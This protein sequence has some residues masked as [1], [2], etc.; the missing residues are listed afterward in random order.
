VKNIR[1][2]IE[3]LAA[4]LFRRHVAWATH[5]DIAFGLHL[6][7]AM[8]A[9]VALAWCSTNFSV[10]LTMPKSNTFT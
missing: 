1:A 3:L 6:S 9:S 2:P 7:V 5:D 8:K 4:R 10:S